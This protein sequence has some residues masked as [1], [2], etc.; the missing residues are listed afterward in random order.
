[1]S[2]HL[3]DASFRYGDSPDL[4]LTFH[5]T[6]GLPCFDGRG[7]IPVPVPDTLKTWASPPGPILKRLS[8]GGGWSE[9]DAD[10]ADA[11]LEELR[12]S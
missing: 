2:V 11:L 1:M 3:A 12:G 6:C 5:E 9:V 10:K 7:T 4:S 8:H